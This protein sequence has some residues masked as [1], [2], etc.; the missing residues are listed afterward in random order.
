MTPLRM[1][2]MCPRPLEQ[3]RNRNLEIL[4]VE[5]APSTWYT[6]SV[7]GQGEPMNM[8]EPLFGE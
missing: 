1:V 8:S 2:R 6:G 3:C 7:H 5:G 4:H